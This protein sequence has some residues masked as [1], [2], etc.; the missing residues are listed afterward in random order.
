MKEGLH[1]I[2]G[3][4]LVMEHC[5]LTLGPLNPSFNLPEHLLFHLQN[6]RVVLNFIG[7]LKNSLRKK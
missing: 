4:E 6:K 5:D 1:A 2:L 3:R 7:H